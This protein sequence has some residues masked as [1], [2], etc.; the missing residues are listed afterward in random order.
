MLA[1]LA[2][3]LVMFR[4]FGRIGLFTLI[5]AAI[6]LCNI[7]VTKTVVLFGFT[8]TLGN[9]LYGAVFLATDL[10]SEF[11]GKQEAKRGVMFGFIF[12]L[13]MTA[14]MQISL[15][16]KPDPQSGT[17][18]H[19]AMKTIFDY[20]P[21]IALGSLVAYLISQLHDVWSYNYWKKRTEGRLLWLRNNLSTI[22]SQLIDSVIFCFIAFW[23][24]FEPAV[25]WE[26]LL[27]TYLFKVAV[28]AVDTPFIYLAKKFRA[29]ELDR[30]AD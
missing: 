15:L 18:V 13:F 11:Y 30:A 3:T 10:L 1:V 14:V 21:R 5:G 27:T 17:A 4:W 6:I 28:A 2:T 22:I 19:N 9:V 7:Q 25:F 16:I 8:M 24:V 23:G 26:I 12:L 29:R 20:V